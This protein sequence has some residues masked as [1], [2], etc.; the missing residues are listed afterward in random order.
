MCG[1][2]RWVRGCAI[3]DL[4]LMSSLSQFWQNFGLSLGPPQA[5]AEL[6]PSLPV[7]SSPP[8]PKWDFPGA[9][10]SWQQSLPAWDEDLK[11]SFT[12]ATTTAADTLGGLS[13]VTLLSLSQRPLISA[14]EKK[15]VL[16]ARSARRVA[17]GVRLHFRPHPAT[18]GPAKER[19]PQMF[20]VMLGLLADVQSGKASW[21]ETETV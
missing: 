21:K 10:E 9:K 11:V 4:C 8:C 6:C 13:Q 15:A 14:G 20:R 19:F 17:A 18:A 2:F 3:C 5:Q 7:A 12:P 16:G 1:S